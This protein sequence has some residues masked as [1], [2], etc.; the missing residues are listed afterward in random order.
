VLHISF[1]GS[2]AAQPLLSQIARHFDIDVN[3][4]YGQVEMIAGHPFGTLIVSVPA[5]AD[6]TAKITAQLEGS[7][8]TV[9][10]LGYVA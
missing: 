7:G 8:N 10:H 5:S 4:I 1:R 6:L 2:E 9:E 3:I